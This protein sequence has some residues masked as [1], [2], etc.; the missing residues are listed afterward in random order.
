MSNSVKKILEH[1]DT[2]EGRVIQEL[3]KIGISSETPEVIVPEG[4]ESLITFKGKDPFVGDL[5]TASD[6]QIGMLMSFFTNWTIYVHTEEERLS[7]R[8][9][10]R[11]QKLE[12]LVTALKKF[13]KTTGVKTTDLKIEVECYKLD[14][15]DLPVFVQAHASWL[16]MD[17][18]HGAVEQRHKDLRTVL[19]AISREQSRRA[20]E[21]KNGNRSENMSKSTYKPSGGSSRW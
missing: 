16:E 7:R 2:L 17:L 20:S 8:K 14:E 11:K 4:L 6:Q 9:N 1:Y 15:D 21:F 3:E 18:L 10:I 5:T 12:R 13:L 19:N